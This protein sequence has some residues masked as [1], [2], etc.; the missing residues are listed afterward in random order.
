M[1]FCAS[2][3]SDYCA[4]YIT[5]DSC[6]DLALE[7]PSFGSRLMVHVHPWS[8][9]DGDG[10]GKEAPLQ[11]S[12]DLSPSQHERVAQGGQEGVDRNG[13]MAFEFEFEVGSL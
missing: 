4:E 8:L 12:Q 2:E 7:E 13:F 5:E 3:E 1:S 9:Q 11:Q 10:S 6:P